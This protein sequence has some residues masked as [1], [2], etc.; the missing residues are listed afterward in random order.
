MENGGEKCKYRQW[1]AVH[2]S[3]ND[4]KDTEKYP[5]FK[6]NRSKRWNIF[7]LHN[8]PLK[9][10]RLWN[11]NNVNSSIVHHLYA[12]LHTFSF[13]QI[14]KSIATSIKIKNSPIPRYKIINILFPKL[15]LTWMNDNLK[16]TSPKNRIIRWITYHIKKLEG[17]LLQRHRCTKNC[18]PLSR[19][20]RM[21]PARTWTAGLYGGSVVK[22]PL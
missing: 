11:E 9:E 15:C 13:Q 19:C 3:T 10:A 6:P 17:N 18:I 16:A 4:Q 7:L 22:V 1:I 5:T 21:R 8:S 12:Q 20:N 14:P 2:S